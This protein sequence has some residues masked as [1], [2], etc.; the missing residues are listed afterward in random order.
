MSPLETEVV[1][2]CTPSGLLVPSYGRWWRGV[3]WEVVEG[4]EVYLR[5]RA[6]LS[7]GDRV[8]ST[9][10]FSISSGL[11]CTNTHTHTHA[12]TVALIILHKES[13]LEIMYECREPGY[14]T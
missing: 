9:I 12:H 2:S 7:M 5:R 4:E 14:S 8:S 1:S 11:I 6:A 13:V 3:K 10:S